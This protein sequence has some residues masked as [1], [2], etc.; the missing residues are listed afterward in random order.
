MTVVQSYNQ[1]GIVVNNVILPGA[2]LLLPKTSFLWNVNSMEDITV[3]SLKV[4]TMLSPRI[5]VCI[6]GTGNRT[7]RPPAELISWFGDQGISLDFMDSVNAF[8]TF[9]VLTQ[10]G[11]VAAAA[12]LPVEDYEKQLEA[13]KNASG[14]QPPSE[15]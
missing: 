11:R 10:E 2:V 7:R 4:L 12:C 1:Y 9:N 6:L 13:L 14:G 8:A 15:K 5:E 3:D